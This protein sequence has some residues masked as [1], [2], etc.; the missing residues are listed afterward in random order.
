[1]PSPR[2]RLQE[3]FDKAVASISQDIALV[4][5]SSGDV[6]PPDPQTV[7]LVS[8]LTVQYMGRLVDAALDAREILHPELHADGGIPPLP[9]PPLPHKNHRAA[10]KRRREDYW[11]EPLPEPKIRSRSSGKAGDSASAQQQQQKT[12]ADRSTTT[13]AADAAASAEPPAPEEWVGAA[14]VDLFEHSRAR[15]AYVRGIGSQQFMFP[16]CHD[17]YVY[18]R[19]REVQAAR[20]SAVAPLL[21]DPALHETVQTEG[22]S[23]LAREREQQRRLRKTGGGGTKP[24]GKAGKAGKAGRKRD[25]DAAVGNA[26]DPEDD[27]DSEGSKSEDEGEGPEWPGLE[28]LLPAHRNYNS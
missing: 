6:L 24:S 26:S 21:R 25:G 10:P 15:A 11:D 7:Q 2:E 27:D 28:K 3:A 4:M 1:M 18:G 23:L 14:G 20:L 17:S 9:P 16:V 13:A 19:I 5:H 12:T 8:A 22:R